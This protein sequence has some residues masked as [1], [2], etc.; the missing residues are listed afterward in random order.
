[1]SEPLRSLVLRRSDLHL[2]LLGPIHVKPGWVALH[3]GAEP[4][5]GP[6]CHD[7][8]APFTHGRVRGPDD[9]P[10]L[11]SQPLNEEV[12]SVLFAVP[13][14]VRSG[15]SGARRSCGRR[16]QRPSCPPTLNL[17]RR[18]W[19]KLSSVETSQERLPTRELRS[20]ADVP[21]RATDVGADRAVGRLVGGMPPEP[22]EHFLRGEGSR[23]RGCVFVKA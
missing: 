6:L 5:A 7:I 9:R 15:W 19:P 13:F 8:H 3:L 21:A 12:L 4:F 11:L 14:E 20:I 2:P 18:R 23:L 1:M 10:A 22:R 17:L 16:V